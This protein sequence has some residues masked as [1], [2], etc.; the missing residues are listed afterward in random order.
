MVISVRV[1]TA[2]KTEETVEKYASKRFFMSFIYLC[3]NAGTLAR[4]NLY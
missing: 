4:V 2:A 3:R 1:S